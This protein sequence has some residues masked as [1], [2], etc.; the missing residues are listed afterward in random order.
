[1]SSN[2]PKLCGITYHTSTAHLTLNL[3]SAKCMMCIIQYVPVSNGLGGQK[4]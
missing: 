1:M 2:V 4:E 3:Y